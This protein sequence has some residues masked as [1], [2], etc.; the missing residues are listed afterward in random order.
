MTLRADWRD[1]PNKNVELPSERTRPTSSIP[2][3]TSKQKK[4]AVCSCTTKQGK[5]RVV[6][7]QD[8]TLIPYALLLRLQHRAKNPGQWRNCYGRVHWDTHFST[9]TTNLHP[10]GKQGQVLHPEEDRIL[11]VRECARSQGIPDFSESCGSIQSKP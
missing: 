5:C 10:D 4:P 7:R 8:N 11:S 9:T 1:L 6:D 3:L 2:T